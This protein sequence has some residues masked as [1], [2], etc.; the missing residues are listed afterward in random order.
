MSR[1][2]RESPKD[3]R[4]PDP[5][6]LHPLFICCMRL[7][8]VGFR[9]T[10]I[11]SWG[12]VLY[13]E[14]AHIIKPVWCSPHCLP[15]DNDVA[16]LNISGCGLL[17]A[18]SQGNTVV[19]FCCLTVA[20]CSIFPQRKHLEKA[21]TMMLWCTLSTLTTGMDVKGSFFNSGTSDCECFLFLS[22]LL[23]SHE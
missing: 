22:S 6:S 12:N 18:F 10:P 17:S 3:L 14:L 20:S 7:E 19:R 9:D 2:N 15:A 16:L 23:S 21:L 4:D 1:M 11:Q 5:R 13:M 8:A